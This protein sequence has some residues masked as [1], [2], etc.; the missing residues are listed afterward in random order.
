MPLGEGRAGGGSDRAGAR[1]AGVPTTSL[2]PMPKEATKA[3]KPAQTMSH[4][5]SCSSNSE[6]LLWTAVTSQRAMKPRTIE[7]TENPGIFGAG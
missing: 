5:K 1:D 7:G 2:A 4:V 6:R 3:R